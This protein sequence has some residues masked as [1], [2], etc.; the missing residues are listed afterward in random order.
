MET[1][2]QSN[3]S[4]KPIHSS[5]RQFRLYFVGPRYMYSSYDTMNHKFPILEIHKCF[6]FRKHQTTSVPRSANNPKFR[7][8]SRNHLPQIPV[9][10]LRLDN[11][12]HV[13]TNSYDETT[14]RCC[15]YSLCSC[16]VLAFYSSLRGLC[17]SF[18]MYIKQIIIQGFKRYCRFAHCWESHSLTST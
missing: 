10:D 3:H 5:G 15:Q 2:K 13:I 12:A 8:V 17:T 6:I 11:I 9:N 7:R 4:V 16:C 14:I 18:E 1:S